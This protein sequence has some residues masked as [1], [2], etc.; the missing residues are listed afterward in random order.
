MSR[1]GRNLGDL[2]PPGADPGHVALI[3]LGAAGGPCA[4]THGAV[5]RAA[6]SVARALRGRGHRP[7]E[8]IAILSANRAEFLV[9][10]LGTMRAGLVSVPVSFKFPPET[11]ELILR[12]A[13]AS[14]VFADAERR[15]AVP[16]GFPIVEIGGDGDGFAG[17][18][19]GG[20]A[21][22]DGSPEPDGPFETATPG[23]GDIAM[24]L[25]TSGSTGRPKGVPLTHTGQWWAIDQR[26]ALTPDL[27]RHRIL[28]A[29]P[30][31]H[32]NALGVAKV[33]LAAHASLVLLPQFSAPAY[34]EAAGRYRCTWL[35]AVPTMMAL[36]AQESALLADA[37]LSSVERVNLG[38]APLT[39]ALVDQVR[40]IFPRALLTNGYGTTETG[41]LAF[42][43]HPLG[44]PRPDL[45]LGYPIAGI[46]LRLVDG[47]GDVGEQGVLELRTPALMP[48]YLNLPEKTAEVMTADGFYRTGDVLR[49][50]AQGF[51]SFVGRADDM[52][53]CGGE[54]IYPS[55]VETMLE[56]HPAVA[57]ASVVAVDDP[58]RG[59]K[60]VAFVVP[61]PGHVLTVEAVKEWALR[62]APAYQHPRHVELV[63]ALPLAGTGKID[64]RALQARAA[65]RWPATRPA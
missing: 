62:H 14:L 29:A 10:Y 44:L 19:H 12:D 54:N 43:P 37:D 45:A 27:G 53:V 40:A 35:T 55:A 5:D 36:V 63:A 47:A 31:Y 32:M 7:G 52:F 25:Y 64:R 6:R 58:V 3:D 38:S 18:L 26:L 4:W 34:V 22:R 23:P 11:I 8:R 41:P 57:Q 33:A 28:A 24:I 1:R 49:R 9:A 42:G 65:A 48:G 15:S 59:Q 60:P 39:Q 21:G 50:D 56:R 30:L 51:Y 2:L 20:P 13:G 17:L 16:T 46:D 61:R